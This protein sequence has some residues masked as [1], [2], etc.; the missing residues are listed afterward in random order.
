MAVLSLPSERSH[1]IFI[2]VNSI[3]VFDPGWTNLIIYYIN[4]L[5]SHL[6]EG[7]L[8]RLV[9]LVTYSPDSPV[10]VGPFFVAGRFDEGNLM[11]PTAGI[12]TRN[13][14]DMAAFDGYMSIIEVLKCRTLFASE[15]YSASPGD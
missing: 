3:L 6:S 15:R 12:M 14:L 13:S 11:S 10:V 5:L 7:N 8:P 4:P 1:F 2:L 9:Y